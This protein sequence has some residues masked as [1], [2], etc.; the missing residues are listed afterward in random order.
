M[1]L[2]TR[3]TLFAK[4]F[5][6]VVLPGLLCL[7]PPAARGQQPNARWV[8]AWSTSQQVLGEDRISDA[9]VRMLARV[10]V[11][12]EAIRVRLRVG[13]QCVLGELGLQYARAQVEFERAELSRQLELRTVD[14]GGRGVHRVRQQHRRRAD[15]REG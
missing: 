7:S 2:P 15:G 5:A 11:P 4:I 12:G 13:E 1:T 10:T 8:T 6:T 3:G 14:L 9:T